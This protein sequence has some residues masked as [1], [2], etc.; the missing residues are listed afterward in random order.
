M[1]IVETE[2]EVEMLKRRIKKAD[3]KNEDDMDSLNGLLKK[4]HYLKI[5]VQKIHKKI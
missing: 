4:K 1:V 5:L 2:K 3:L